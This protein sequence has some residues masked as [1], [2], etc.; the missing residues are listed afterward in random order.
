MYMFSNLQNYKN[1]EGFNIAL[2][3]MLRM[4]INVKVYYGMK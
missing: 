2:D 4:Y 1:I 3:N